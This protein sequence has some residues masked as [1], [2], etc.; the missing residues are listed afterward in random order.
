VDRQLGVAGPESSGRNPP[1]EA[2]YADMRSGKPLTLQLRAVSEGRVE[3]SQNCMNGLRPTSSDYVDTVV[4]GQ[5][6][7]P[8]SSWRRSAPSR[9]RPEPQTGIRRTTSPTPNDLQRCATPDRGGGPQWSWTRRSRRSRSGDHIT[10][11]H[12]V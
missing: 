4:R 8:A 2:G 11:S 5:W 3:Y 9:L 12:V 7:R 10:G 6:R 1:H